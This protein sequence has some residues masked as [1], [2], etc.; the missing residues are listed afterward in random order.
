MLFF[1][2]AAGHATA[3]E[4]PKA[5]DD[6]LTVELVASEPE[7]RTPTAIDTD[8]R[9]RV[10][11]LENNT[12]F[13]PKNYDGPPTD[14]V[15][16][17]DDFSANGHANHITVFAEGFRNGMGLRV[18]PDGSALVSTRAETFL[19]R[20]TKGAGH[21]DDHVSLL[22]LET[23]DDYPHNGLSGITLDG[24]G[25]FFV[26]LGEN[27]GQPWVLTDADGTVIRGS[28]EGGIFRCN[29]DGTKLERWAKGFWNPFGL[30]VD[31]AGRLFAL[32]NDPGAGSLC[33]L[34]RVVHDGDYGYRYR[35]GRITDHPFIS[36]FGQIPGKLP[37]VCLV[38]EAPTGILQYHG[39]SLPAE[40]H[41]QLLGCTWS[42]H[43]IQRLPLSERG[44]S[45]SCTP[46]WLV[47]GG[48]DFRPSGIAQAPDG[49]LFI[50]DWVDGSY[51][52]HGK[53]RIWRVRA[54][55]P[56]TA[57]TSVAPVRHAATDDLFD[58]PE[59]PATV[60]AKSF[61][62]SQDPFLFHL[63]IEELSKADQATLDAKLKDAD[64]RVRLAGLLAME[65]GGKT[66]PPDLFAKW[67]ADA[68]G[69]I[70]RAALQW[71]SEEHLTDLQ[72]KLDAALAAPL[73][74]STFEAYL[75]TIQM[76]VSG[77]PDPKATVSQT[78]KIALDTTK[79]ADLRALSVKLLPVDSAALSSSDLSTLL[80]D[81][82]ADV[83]V[84]A[85]RILAARKD[86]A[87]QAQ[88]RAIASDNNVSSSPR[89]D[90]IAGLAWSV[91]KPETD[92]TLREL[93]SNR[94]SAVQREALRALRG[95]LTDDEFAPLQKESAASDDAAKELRE[96]LM[97]QTRVSP[98]VQS[99]GAAPEF[100]A[101]A[102]VHPAPNQPWPAVIDGKGDAAAGRR[103][104]YH[105]MGPRCYTCHTIE[106][107]GGNVGPDLSRIGQL[108]PSELLV[109]I[110]EPS[111]DIAPAFTQFL[112]KLKDGR[113]VNG[114]DAFE[115]NK[116]QTVL[117]DA[118]GTR[119]RYNIS[120]IVSREPLPISLMP[121]GLDNM[122][123]EQELRDLLAF[124]KAQHE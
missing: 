76:L 103:L 25:H 97:L 61:A 73:T 75:A 62:N 40:I 45:F 6:R 26:G 98:A 32:D 90:A 122:M 36:W 55:H 108:S 118:S 11:V 101:L 7:V 43:G 28:D 35:Y 116:S 53:G 107:R 42:D 124:L 51:E 86:D 9:G 70:R 68:D 49:S 102:T 84:E 48:N 38:G 14:R 94:D 30:T 34:L 4:E 19:L 46:G 120:D 66:A 77:T 8:S 29:L 20:D 113:E 93:L 111:K 123:T 56:E 74:R 88:L 12:H 41:G 105:P 50:S 24:A 109:A 69:T 21:A 82:V 60:D 13:R 95:H 79:P 23:K 44:A 112:L 27:H 71:I 16:I 15:L 3:L 1:L 17:L 104:F 78:R 121:P 100:I 33:R 22:K 5:V 117:I 39:T 96:Q 64:P 85:V 52:V 57:E 83:K 18:L 31:D 92:A 65:R 37:P 80:N 114:I 63:A 72:P 10:W 89:A 115:D 47:R 91:G 99:H 110:R 119:T 2:G 81:S 59:K 67:L 106:G 87:A 54:K 58:H